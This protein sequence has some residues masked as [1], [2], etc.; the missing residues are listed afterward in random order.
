MFGMFESLIVM[1]M[2]D[3][4]NN[5]AHLQKVVRT[6]SSWEWKVD[7]G[8]Y[9]V[10][11]I[12]NPIVFKHGLVTLNNSFGVNTHNSLQIKKDL[13]DNEVPMLNDSSFDDVVEV[14]LWSSNGVN[15]S[16]LSIPPSKANSSVPKSNDSSTLSIIDVLHV[17]GK[18]Y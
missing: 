4:A 5:S 13:V 3:I 16:V 8:S 12:P 11:G 1:A 7:V 9:K 10:W 2:K 15:S 17:F 6:M 18:S 14:E